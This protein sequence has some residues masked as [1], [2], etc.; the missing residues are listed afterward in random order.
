MNTMRKLSLMVL[1]CALMMGCTS[2]VVQPM[3]ADLAVFTG[4]VNEQTRKLQTDRDIRDTLELAPLARFPTSLAIVRVQSAAARSHSHGV[5][6]GT[7]AYRVVLNTTVENEEHFHRLGRLDQVNSAV[8]LNRLIIGERN[9]TS[10]ALRNGA[11]RLHADLLLIY[12]INTEWT[13]DEDD[14]PLQAITLGISK[15]KD[16]NVASTATALLVGS[17]NGYVYATAEVTRD[18]Q[19]RDNA[20]RNGDEIE[21]AQETLEQQAFDGLVDSFVKAWPGVV[22]AYGNPREARR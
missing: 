22:R 7:G 19:Y 17:H 18:K 4:Q 3:G 6:Y 5:S 20:W 10:Q 15:Y 8:R 1:L 16:V 21:A 14:S 2:H 12:T 11:A 9:Q 13:M